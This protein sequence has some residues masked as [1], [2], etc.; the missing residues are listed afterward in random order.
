MLRRQFVVSASLGAFILAAPA[1]AATGAPT[2]T[3]GDAALLALLDAI[4]A[5]GVRHSPQSATSYGLDVGSLAVLRTRLNPRGAAA[6]AASVARNRGYAAQL[7]RVDAATLSAR[8]K[9]QLG[10]AQDIIG[11]RISAPTRFGIGDAQRPYVLTQQQ[12]AYF[13]IPDFLNATH[14]IK[15]AA[16]CEAYL[17]RLTAFATAL[18]QDTAEQARQARR[19]FLAPGWSL[20][21]VLGQLGALRGQQAEGSS[22]VQSLVRRAHDKGIEGAWQSRASAIVNARIYPAL[23]RQIALVRRLRPATRAGDGAT[24]RLPGGAEIYALAL[25]QATTTALTP[26]QVHARGLAEVADIT[27]RLDTILTA[28]GMSA[29]T[30]GERLTALNGRADQLYPDS[31]AGRAGLIASLNR[32]IDAMMAKLPQAFSRQPAHPLTIR[33]VPVEIQDGASNGYYSSAALDGSR[34]AIYWINLKNV[35]NWPKY[36]LPALTYHEGVPG[37]HLQI[38]YAQSAGALPML[39]KNYSYSAYGEGWALYAEQ[40]ADELGGYRGLERAGYLQSF[41]FRAARLVV[42]TGIHAMGWSRERATDYMVAATGFARPRCQSE[43]ERYCT[44][45][46]QACSY[47][48]GHRAWVDAREKA[49]AALGPRFDLKWFHDVLDDGAMPLTMLAERIEARTRERLMTMAG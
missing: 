5:D 18:D 39:L 37:H 4:F 31:D 28:A 8:G 25:A 24:Q 21:L 1:I 23:D 46:G 35:G 49:Q 47:K 43:V 11:Q 44:M 34:P 6:Q 2:P 17:A 27:G 41:L 42:D 30:V 20:D 22:I 45:M 38:N 19:G 48:I 36:S 29:G 33:R 14:P 40:L 12:G 13:E 7:A 32:G 26:A 3:S 15:T 10:V 9:L 16:D